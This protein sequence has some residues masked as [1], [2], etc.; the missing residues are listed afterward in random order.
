MVDMNSGTN[1]I[2]HKKQYIEYD[3]QGNKWLITEYSSGVVTEECLTDTYIV[4]K[5]DSKSQFEEFK[6]K[7]TR[8]NNKSIPK[9]KKY[10]N[11]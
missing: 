9:R 7:K 6:I 2:L 11:F 5:S 10:L 1:T 4:T 3:E 8:K